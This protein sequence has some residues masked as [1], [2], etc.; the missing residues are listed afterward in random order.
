MSKYILREYQQEAVTK[1]IEHFKGSAR[2]AVIVLPTG[3][4]KSL[5]IAEL[6]KRARGKIIVLAHVKELVEQNYDKFRSFDLDAGIFSAGLNQKNLEHP[7]T[8]ASVQS[9]ARN[10][11]QLSTSYSL[12][13]I[14][15][16][17]RLSDDENSQYQKIITH[18]KKLNPKM[19]VLGLTATPYRLGLVGFTNTITEAIYA[20]MSPD[21]LIT[22]Y[23]NCRLDI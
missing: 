20:V 4:G 9:L 13:I 19:R 7:V 22:V 16:C 15:E 2:S 3:A 14:D 10:L 11:E 17:H 1:T 21:R 18:L 12:L 5:V 6:A 8:F 23:T